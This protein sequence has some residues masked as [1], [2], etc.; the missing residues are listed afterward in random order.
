MTS[1]KTVTTK[2]LAANRHN[3]QRST[4][5]RTPKGKARSRWNALKHGVLA[6]AIIPE[7][8]LPCE[9]RR[10][11]DRL[12]AT[13]R[14]EFTPQSAIEEMLVETVATCYWRLG[15]ILRAEAAAISRRLLSVEDNLRQD[16]RLAYTWASHDFSQGHVGTLEEQLIALSKCMRR[17][18]HLRQ[19]MSILDS[20]WRDASEE[21]LIDA[22]QARLDHVKR[23]LDEKESQQLAAHRGMSSIPDIDHALKL[24]SYEARLHRQLS[25]ALDEL[26]R[27]QRRHAGESVPPPL[28]V[29]ITDAS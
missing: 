9:S 11:F 4:G 10:E 26:E 12:L 15:R 27:I 22:A 19:L 18:D 20:R 2:Q 28:N 5:P 25:R 21:Q 29:T 6:Q 14:G 23:Q 3:A 16:R 13:L 17:T 1:P 8:L 7:S 24:S